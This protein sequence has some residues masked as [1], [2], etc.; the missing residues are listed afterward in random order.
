M[1]GTSAIPRAR[2]AWDASGQPAV[3][4]WSVSAITSS[5]ASLAAAI[6]TFGAW[7]PSE[8]LEWACRSI[9]T[10][11]AYFDGGAPPRPQLADW[12]QNVGCR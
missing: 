8:I 3:E 9:L 5:P 11:L 7:V 2:A 12:W 4:S 6:S 10:P 1:P